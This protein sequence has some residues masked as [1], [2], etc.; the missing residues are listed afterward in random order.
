MWHLIVGAIV[1]I[2]GF[3]GMMH[4]GIQAPAASFCSFVFA[5]IASFIAPAI[6]SSYFNDSDGHTINSSNEENSQNTDHED[7]G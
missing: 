1:Y 2:T 7:E 3:M 4:I 6:I 5:F